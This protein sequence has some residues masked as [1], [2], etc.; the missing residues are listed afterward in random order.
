M[1]WG[2]DRSGIR[3]LV[4]LV[5][6]VFGWVVLFSVFID[7]AS[8][9]R[10]SARSKLR[11]PK[12]HSAAARRRRGAATTHNNKNAPKKPQKPRYTYVLLCK[13]HEIPDLDAPKGGHGIRRMVR[14]DQ[15]TSY[16]LGPIRGKWCLVPFQMAV[17]FGTATLYIVAG[18]QD[19][20]AFAVHVNT[21]QAMPV[22]GY[23]LV[24]AGLQL[25]LSMLP[26]FAELTFVSL[27]GALMSVG[28]RSVTGE[29]PFVCAIADVA[30]T[31]VAPPFPFVWFECYPPTQRHTHSST[32]LNTRDT[33]STHNTHDTL[34]AHTATQTTHNTHTATHNTT[35]THH[36]HTHNT[37]TTTHRTHNTQRDRHRHVLPRQARHERRHV[38]PR[39]RQDA[40]RGRVW[41]V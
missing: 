37:H 6:F 14:Y 32:P 5:R 9:K 19:L 16:L 8:I 27:L 26:S 17:L 4:L 21:S 36:K 28:Y 18:G 23:Y 3:D 40:R 30:A 2:N 7:L 15:L 22:W 25:L 34:N 35:H 29:P 1:G 12:C 13:M 11:L 33:H 31:R 10:R 39:R 20:Y 24:F 38:R 41:R